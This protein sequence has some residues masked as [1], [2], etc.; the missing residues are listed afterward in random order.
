MHP[1]F[2]LL[3]ANGNRVN[4]AAR[5]SPDRTCGSCHDAVFINSTSTHG[6]KG[7]RAG[8]VECHLDGARIV[9]GPGS[10]T[11]DGMLKKGAFKIHVPRNRNCA[12]CHGIVNEGTVPV[13]VPVDFALA[14]KYVPGGKNYSIT[15]RTGEVIS[16]QD[17]SE[18]YLNLK[19]KYSLNFPWDTHS[20]REV[21]CVSC[22]FAAN[23]P[24]KCGSGRSDLAFLANDPRKIN[25]IG[26]YLYRPDHGLL[27]AACTD[28]HSPM[29]VHDFLPY[30]RRHFEALSCQSCH[31][32]GLYGPAFRSVDATVVG[33]DGGARIEYRNAS[34]AG[35]EVTL[36]TAPIQGYEP[37]LFSDGRGRGPI[38]PYNIVTSWRWV[39]GRGE[40]VPAE[41]IRKAYLD[42]GAY[43]GEIIS[44]LDADRNGTIEDGELVLDTGEKVGAVKM[45]LVSL[46]VKNPSIAGAVDSYRVNHGIADKKVVRRDCGGCH[47]P[48]SRLGSSIVLSSAAPA[49][50]MPV[51]SRDMTASFNG[52]FVQREKSIEA[53]RG[54]HVRGYY[55][56]GFSR[57]WWLNLAGFAVFFMT[58]AGIA[59]HA[60][61][62][63]ISRVADEARGSKRVYMYALYERIWH[64]TMALSVII[65]ILTGLGIHYTGG[66]SGIFG[67]KTIVDIHNFFAFIVT[68]NAGLSL[69]YHLATGQIRMFFISRGTFAKEAIAQAV[70][71]LHG[72]FRGAPHP[73]EKTPEKRL[74][75]LQQITYLLLLNV[76]FPFQI[77]TGLLMWA[78][79]VSGMV[80]GAIGGLSVVAPLHNLGSWFFMTF[81]VLHVY[82]TTTGRTV[83]SSTKAMITGY[84]DLEDGGPGGVQT[85][86]GWRDVVDNIKS[87]IRKYRGAKP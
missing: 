85:A 81:L 75:P 87:I 1:E 68:L 44:A 10:F 22:H 41:L 79:G 46:G 47:G 64:W 48:D 86:A 51:L 67:F 43:I 20:Q 19:D 71:Y 56:F 50:V 12:T 16:S 15:Q 18:S 53:E 38:S 74:N 82:L 70:Y 65:L 8:C 45:R 32:P 54:S 55:V 26:K 77:L 42:S 63:Y 57:V 23:D 84:E 29:K 83:F 59:A 25:P 73:V 24:K 76:L 5:V 13:E 78:V 6:K 39:D 80:S 3:D 61:L 69:F 36:N 60:S 66:G 2:H 21:Y 30:K 14:L 11:A 27:K 31:V 58:F 17:L 49:G 33:G 7:V 35:G 52:R 37:Y 28:C 4:D 72:I 40:P 62:R 34:A 9:A